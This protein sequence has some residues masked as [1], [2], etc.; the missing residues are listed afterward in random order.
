MIPVVR[1]VDVGRGNTK[2]IESIH[3]GEPKCSMFPSKACPAE[4]PHEHDAWNKRRDTVCIPVDDLVYE[5]GPDVHLA[6]DVFEA[7]VLQHDRYCDTAEYMA[8]LL[9]AVHYMNVA[10]IDL[11]IVGLPVAT[12]KLKKTVTALEKKLEG[13]HRLGKG[14]KVTIAK[15]KAIGQPS[16]A[17][18]S[19]GLL[20]NKLADIRK[21]RSLIVDAGRRTFD[22]LVTHGMQ[23]VEKRSHSANRG[24]FDVLQ[25]L[26]EGICRTT[27][28]QYCDFDAVDKALRENKKPV[29]FQKEYEIGQHLP[30]A[31]K[32]PEQAVAEMLRYVGDAGDIKN[33]ILVGGGAFFYKK[34]LK[35]AFPQHHI[36]ELKDAMFANVKGFYY[37]GTELVKVKGTPQQ[38][39]PPHA[40]T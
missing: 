14:R 38:T 8:L 24:M 25:T 32:I 19:Y 26:I 39:V 5:V 10:H 34:A 12:F 40:T 23:F 9:G 29:I 4:V 20:H 7:N 30:L 33:I 1:A 16:G 17:L 18:M 27:N 13:E 21:E 28:S 36:H 35:A 11:L 22:W 2:F 15:A 37:A 6:A 3:N 31:R